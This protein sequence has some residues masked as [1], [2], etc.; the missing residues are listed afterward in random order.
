MI[1][2]NAFKM[3]NFQKHIINVIIF[4][5]YQQYFIFLFDWKSVKK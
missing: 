2:Y 3:I 5:I 4:N 1:L